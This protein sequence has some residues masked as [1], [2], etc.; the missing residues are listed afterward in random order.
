MIKR[1]PS[2]LPYWGCPWL[3]LL[4]LLFLLL[5][6]CGCS[7]PSPM[8]L[9]LAKHAE[10]LLALE[11]GT[12]VFAKKY[13][14]PPPPCQ[15]LSLSLLRFPTMVTVIVIVIETVTAVATASFSFSGIPFS[16]VARLP[17]P[18]AGLPGTA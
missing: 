9:L 10:T 5:P 1:N 7:G 15:K 6:T 8:A 11:A 16:L 2:A 14:I 4:L 12:T 17:R 3:L 13:G 18:S